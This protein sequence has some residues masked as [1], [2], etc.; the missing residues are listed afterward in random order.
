MASMISFGRRPMPQSC[1]GMAADAIR[2]LRHMCNRNRDQLLGLRRN[3]TFSEHALAERSEGFGR[4][5]SQSVSLLGDLPSC[6][7]IHLFVF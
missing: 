1:T 2:A 3:R 6:L 5:R 7:R 4:L